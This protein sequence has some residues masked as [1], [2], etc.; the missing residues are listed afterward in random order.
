M[1]SAITCGNFAKIAMINLVRSQKILVGSLE[2]S[3]RSLL[4]SAAN[5]KICPLFYR[6]LLIWVACIQLVHFFIWWRRLMILC[7]RNCM[8]KVTGFCQ[9][10]LLT[11]FLLVLKCFARS[12]F[13]N[14][15]INVEGSMP[16]WK[17]SKRWKKY[18]IYMWFWFVVF[19]LCFFLSV[20]SFFFVVATWKGDL[21]LMWRLRG[22]KKD[23]NK[24]GRGMMMLM[25]MYFSLS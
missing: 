20:V 4:G 10:N 5:M 24:R 11:K 21:L 3:I 19:S 14:T 17:L 1:I 2:N 18:V 13:M 8:T 15:R 23:L 7:M 25:I 12:I 16:L 22:G 6:L 9:W